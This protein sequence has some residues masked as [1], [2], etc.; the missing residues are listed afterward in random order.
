MTIDGEF[1]KNAFPVP[2]TRNETKNV[3]TLVVSFFVYKYRLL[4]EYDTGQRRSRRTHIRV[5]VLIKTTGRYAGGEVVASRPEHSRHRDRS[6]TSLIGYLTTGVS[7]SPHRP[8]Q[9]APPGAFRSIFDESPRV[10]RPPCNCASDP[11]NVRFENRRPS[12]SIGPVTSLPVLRPR[13][14]HSGNNSPGRN[15]PNKKRF[16][17][18]ERT[19]GTIPYAN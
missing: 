12:I 13:G 18:P 8:T 7:V 5:Y 9:R 2:G 1:R 14:T 4:G 19:S 11:S 17:L 6:I 3:H 15:Y 16:F 10:T